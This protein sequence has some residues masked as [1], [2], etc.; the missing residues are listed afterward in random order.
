MGKMSRPLCP[1]M[2]PLPFRRTKHQQV[3][4]KERRAQRVEAFEVF[5]PLAAALLYRPWRARGS[6]LAESYTHM[7]LAEFAGGLLDQAEDTR[8]FGF[9]KLSKDF[10]EWQ[11]ALFVKRLAEQPVE[12]VW[13]LSAEDAFTNDGWQKVKRLEAANTAK[14]NISFAD[15]PSPA[16][17]LSTKR[18]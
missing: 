3:T 1:L 17:T 5:P 13:Q 8:R 12:H 16:F 2:P 7:Q 18:F 6:A 15:V 9:Y 4:Q 10:N 11:C 14:M